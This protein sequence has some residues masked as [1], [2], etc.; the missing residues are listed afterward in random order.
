MPCGCV[1]LIS[2]E[3]AL[4][5]RPCIVNN[6]VSIIIII[7]KIIIIIIIIILMGVMPRTARGAPAFTEHRHS[8]S[9]DL[10]TLI[11]TFEF[12][13]WLCW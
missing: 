12:Y 1:F 13:W 6:E 9:P 2:I 10:C 4:I 3:M 5:T 8:K 11:N 7:I